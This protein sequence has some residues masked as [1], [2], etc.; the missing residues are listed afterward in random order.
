MNKAE[1]PAKEAGFKE[2]TGIAQPVRVYNI[3]RFSTH[4]LVAENT[5]AY[6]RGSE[7][8]YP[9]GR[10]HCQAPPGDLSN[11][12]HIFHNGAPRVNRGPIKIPVFPSSVA[13]YCGGRAPSATPRL[14]A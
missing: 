1:A 5:I 2:L 13:G 7:L 10:M 4:R 8:L 3:P 12:L 6:E 14:S 11:L 9:Y